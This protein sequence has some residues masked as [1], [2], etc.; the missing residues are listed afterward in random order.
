MRKIFLLLLTLVAAHFS[1]AQKEAD[2]IRQALKKATREK[3]V[4]LLLS[5]NQVNFAWKGKEM[6]DSTYYYAMTLQIKSGF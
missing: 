6:V 3:K 2:S 4:M 5:V 1:F